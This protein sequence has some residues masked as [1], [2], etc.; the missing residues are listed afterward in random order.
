M[1]Q[2]SGSD[3]QGTIF[4]GPDGGLYYIQDEVLQALKLP[5]NLA[6]QAERLASGAGAQVEGFS[7]EVGQIEPIARVTGGVDEQEAS[8]TPKSTI[9]CWSNK[10]FQTA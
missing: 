5:D 1:A 10:C 8:R 7:M 6:Q 3:A 2:Q 4:R 9:M